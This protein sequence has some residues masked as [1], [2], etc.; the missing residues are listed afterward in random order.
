MKRIF[1][2]FWLLIIANCMSQPLLAQ[3]KVE[4]TSKIDTENKSKKPVLPTKPIH[5]LSEK[6]TIDSLKMAIAQ[7]SNGTKALPQELGAIEIIIVFLLPVLFFIL[8]FSFVS[9]A[10]NDEGF[11]LSNALSACPPPG[12]V[13]E[14]VNTKTQNSVSRLIAFM[15]G[16]VA[17][18]LAV[19]F[20]SFYMYY[21]FAWNGNPPNLETFWK[22]VASL[23]I[24]V[25]PY[26]VNQIKEAMQA[27]KPNPTTA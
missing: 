17:V 26:G 8:V 25:V 11:Y 14:Q 2:L 4:Q 12:T 15:T 13:S 23:G 19:C 20:S 9:W 16:V 5:R 3:S 24:G 7:M 21:S 10:R 18:V 27:N 22:V 6:E 1:L